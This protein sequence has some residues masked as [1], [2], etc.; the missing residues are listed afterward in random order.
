MGGDQLII[1]KVGE[2]VIQIMTND[3]G[4][5]PYYFAFHLCDGSLALG[6]QEFLINSSLMVYNLQTLDT[7]ILDITRGRSAVS[8]LIDWG[9]PGEAETPPSW[10]VI[11][12]FMLKLRSVG[13]IN[14]KE[15]QIS[16]DTNMEWPSI[17][18]LYLTSTD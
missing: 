17:P 10:S 18:S 15:N 13:L 7:N 2:G 14:P 3:N 16:I 1:D 11:F 9:L 5:R 8:S 6:K 4:Y 12:V